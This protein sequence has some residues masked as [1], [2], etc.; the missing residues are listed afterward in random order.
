MFPSHDRGGLNDENSSVQ[1][2][3]AI[4]KNASHD[5]IMK[6]VRSNYSYVVNAALRNPNSTT[7]HIDQAKHKDDDYI[8]NA[9][10]IHPEATKEHLTRIVNGSTPTHLSYIQD[11]AHQRLADKDYK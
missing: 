2:S 4:H 6:G 11:I 10:V 9:I 3:A 1:A 7:E 5:Q 8:K